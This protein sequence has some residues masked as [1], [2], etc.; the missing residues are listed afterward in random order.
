MISPA[1]ESLLSGLAKKPGVHHAVLAVESGDGAFAWAGATGDADNTGRPMTADTPYF[2][3]SVTKLY[4]AAVVLR[5]V[6]RDEVGLD[7]PF[8]AYLP[9]GLANRLHVFDGAD[10]TGAITV[11]HLLSHTSG[12][13]D[14][15]EDKPRTGP[16]LIDRILAEGDRD[17]EIDEI[18]RTVRDDLTPHF[19]PQPLLTEQSVRARYSDTNFALAIAI[20]EA[21]SGHA[22]HEAL[23]TELLEPLGLLRTWAA[24]VEP[25]GTPTAPSALWAGGEMLELPRLLKSLGDM[26]STVA[27][28]FAF[29]RALLSGMAFDDPATATLMQQHWNTFGFDPGTPRLP[30]WPI[31][32]GLGTMRFALPRWLT[33]FGAVP[34][35]VGHTGS[36]GCWLFYC[37]ELDIYTCGAVDN[38]AAGAVPFRAVPKVLRA[39]AKECES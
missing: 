14:Y 27:D 9:S 17:L 35:V 33:P 7:E 11:R 28:Q 38:A 3:A 10:H 19:P 23:A 13:P 21:V 6:E 5:L 18:C 1:L 36:T 15:L 24:G 32:Y 30:G 4:I 29:M 16:R 34:A 37:P 12:L 25:P 20:I 2:V 39:V 31:A 8:A 22:W 26:Y